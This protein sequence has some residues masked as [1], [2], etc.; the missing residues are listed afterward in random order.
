Q[1]RRLRQLGDRRGPPVLQVSAHHLGGRGV[2]VERS[3]RDRRGVVRL[4]LRLREQ[5]LQRRAPLDRRPQLHVRRRSHRDRPPL[6]D[7]LLEPE[8]PR[9]VAPEGGGGQQQV[10]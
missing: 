1:P 6:P 3:R 10:V 7:Q 9:L 5:Q 4:D 2:P 8:P